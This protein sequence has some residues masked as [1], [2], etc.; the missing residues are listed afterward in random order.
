MSLNKIESHPFDIWP[1]MPEYRQKEYSREYL[2][3]MDR[4]AALTGG[5]N[6]DF[7][8]VRSLYQSEKGL[9]PPPGWEP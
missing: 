5:L 7:S 2:D 8:G 4:I 3:I 1:L 9:Q 6:P